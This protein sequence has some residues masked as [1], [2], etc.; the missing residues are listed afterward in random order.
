V[1]LVLVSC[2][3]LSSISF[4][5]RRPLITPPVFF[6]P[7]SE[8]G[9]SA[10][11]QGRPR[12]SSPSHLSPSPPPAEAHRLD[13]PREIPDAASQPPPDSGP[14]QDAAAGNAPEGDPEG[15]PDGEAD[16]RRG[17]RCVGEGC[18]PDGPLGAGPGIPGAGADLDPI[19]HPGV[20][21]VTEPVLIES[22][23]VLP[24]YPELARRAG[25]SG[26]VILE[27]IIQIDG[28]VASVRVLRETPA[29]VGFG[30]AAKAA[31]ERWRYR[32]GT[33]EDRPVAVYF[34]VIVDFALAR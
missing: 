33:Q 24:R 4:P 17:G 25:V 31:V 21:D 11:K 9:A 15:V 10:A 14:L 13:P 5:K 32:P 2:L 18:H 29:H 34:T 20:G 3:T 1:S 12:S 19:R 8:A 7:L 27:A 26:R 22:S 30:E 28:T 6:F 16:G 23:K